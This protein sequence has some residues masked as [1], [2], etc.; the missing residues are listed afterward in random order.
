MLTTKAIHFYATALLRR[1][2]LWLHPAGCFLPTK[3]VSPC[4]V[5]MRATLLKLTQ[6]RNSLLCAARLR[7]VAQAHGI[8]KVAKAASVERESLYRAL[9][10]KGNPRLSTLFAVTRA[11][12]LNIT[13]EA[14]QEQRA[15]RLLRAVIFAL[16]PMYDAAMTIAAMRVTLD[17]L[18]A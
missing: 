10:P 1:Q 12:R 5:G 6:F 18:R 9:S 3:A 11:L 7:A 15:A 8:A 13:I 2:A 16:R 4:A 14:A 17:H